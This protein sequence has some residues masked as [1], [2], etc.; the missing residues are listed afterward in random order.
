M[1]A[2]VWYIISR[3]SSQKPEA[4]FLTL[5][6]AFDVDRFAPTRTQ[7]FGTIKQLANYGE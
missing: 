1:E 4:I 5:S 3:K 2:K 6:A 7:P